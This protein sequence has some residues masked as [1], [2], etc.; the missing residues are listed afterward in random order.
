MLGFSFSQNTVSKTVN[1]HKKDVNKY[2][3]FVSILG[4]I[5]RHKIYKPIKKILPPQH[6][7]IQQRV[8]AGHKVAGHKINMHI[9]LPLHM[10][11]EVAVSL[12]Y[13]SCY[14]KP[15][16][17]LKL[18]QDEAFITRNRK[19]GIILIYITKNLTLTKFKDSYN[20][21]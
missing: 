17:N 12:R 15:N 5:S 19:I 20:V 10:H 18:K 13:V 4:S 3:I 1:T 11:L 6:C 2:F 16:S 7:R 9:S 21:L 14:A 8:F